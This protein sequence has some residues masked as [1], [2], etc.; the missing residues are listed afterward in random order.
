VRQEENTITQEEELQQAEDI[1]VDSIAELIF[2]QLCASQ[3]QSY[4]Q[5]SSASPLK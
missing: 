4:E 5:R 1:F 2:E 3:K